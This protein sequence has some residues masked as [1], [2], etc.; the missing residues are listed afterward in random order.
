MASGLPVVATAVGGLPELVT[1]GVTGRLVPSGQPQALAEALGAVLD[2]PAGSAAL[3]TAARQRAVADFS[4]DTMAR[5]HEE[6]FLRVMRSKGRENA[7]GGQ[8][9]PG[10][11]PG[12]PR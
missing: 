9:G 7:S 5:R 6:A 12:P 10:A 4:L 8:E 2:D 3:G 1:D 11:P